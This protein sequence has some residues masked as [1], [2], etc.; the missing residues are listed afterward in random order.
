MDFVGDNNPTQLLHSVF[1]LVGISCALRAGKE[2]Q[3]LRSIL[4][5]SQFEWKVDNDARHYLRYCEDLGMK[6]NKGGLKH[7]KLDR[8]VV[9]V[10]P[11]PGSK[12]C[13]VMMI[14]KYLSLL[15]KSRTC[16][17]FYLQPKKKYDSECWYLDKAV[18]INKLQGLV[19]EVCKDAGLPGYYTNHSLRA[20]ATTRMYHSGLDEQ[21]IQ[22]V[23][24]HHS[25]AVR[26]YKCTC[27]SQKFI[28]SSC[29][30]GVESD[31]KPP[32]HFKYSQ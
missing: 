15:P 7:R 30:M 4:F 27:D 11:I 32:K 20:T 25:I 13:P 19:H 23:T 28:A 12:K 18:G 3:K 17:S 29:I 22:E 2:H 1:F 8:K 24:G 9:N 14:M 16:T 5:N 26:E 31:I 6:T 10:Y 21:I